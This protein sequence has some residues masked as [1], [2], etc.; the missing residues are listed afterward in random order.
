ML[1]FKDKKQLSVLI[2]MLVTLVFIFVQSMLPPKVSKEES[3][4]VGDAVSDAVTGV[5]GTDTPEKVEKTDSFREYM[6]ANVRKLAHLFEYAML[7]IETLIF[8]FLI[9][10]NDRRNMH[11]PLPAAARSVLFPL[12]VAFI[13]ESIQFI[14]GRAPSVADMWT[15][16][17]GYICGFALAYLVLI[18]VKAIKHRRGKVFPVE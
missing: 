5:V 6:K 4:A 17:F 2:I 11:I 13:D 18:L 3:D 12:T 1:S 15:D 8:L 7:G 16:I 9:Y 14:S 10:G